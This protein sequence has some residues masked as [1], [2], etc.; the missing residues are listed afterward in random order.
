MPSKQSKKLPPLSNDAFDGEMYSVTL[1]PNKKNDHSGVYFH[2]G[3]LRS[4]SG[5]A[6][7]G[8]NLHLLYEYLTKKNTS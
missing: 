1:D 5:A 2:N 8:P 3:E 7:T 4:P 6:W